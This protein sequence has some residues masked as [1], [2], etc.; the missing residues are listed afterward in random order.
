MSG[1]STF[2]KALRMER[3]RLGLTQKEL[4]EKLGCAQQNIAGME[5]D[6]SL[7]KQD[8]HDKM[9]EVFGQH[10]PVAALPP[11][12]DIAELMERVSSPMYSSREPQT[13]EAAEPEHWRE[14]EF[15][16]LLPH[17]L[18]GYTEAPL[19]YN[20]LSYMAD[21]L[22]PTLLVEVKRVGNPANML[23]LG[24]HG[25]QQLSTMSRIVDTIRLE[26]EPQPKPI[27]ILVTPNLNIDKSMM[28][29]SA[30]AELHG[31]EVVFAPNN[32]SVAELIKQREHSNVS[33]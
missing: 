24:R 22:S 30:E 6:K 33:A 21:Y 12:R 10:S 29:L 11:R 2:A 7:P 9:I 27:L 3:E 19:G 8:L 14:I 1:K 18:R 4:A 25:L 5:N 32:T 28:R 23:N 20:G 17:N 13:T 31:I 26:S 15:V 16:E